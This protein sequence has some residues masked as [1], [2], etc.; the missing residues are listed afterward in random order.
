MAKAEF[1][2]YFDNAPASAEQLALFTEIRIDQGIGIAA[3]A[4]LDLP[5]GTDDAGLWPGI[6]EDFAQ[7]FARVRIEVKVAE[8]DFL[9]L[10][11]GL[12]VGN[13]YEMSAAPNQSLMTL[14]VQDDSVQ[15]SRDEK[16]A[17][18]E[19]MAPADIVTSLFTDAGLTAEVDAAPDA[20]AALQRVIVQRGTSMQLLRELA[21]RHGMFVYVRPGEAPG[22]S[23]G[24]FKRPRLDAS[25]LPEIMLVG[26]KRN[27]AS[28][29]AEFDAL[30]PIKAQA[31][32]VS[33]ADKSVLSSQ[34]EAA[35]IAPLGDSAA[36]DVTQAA[37]VLL[38]G[39]RE[40]Q[41]DLDAATAATVELS[42]WAY[43]A[44]GELDA[45]HY[46]GVMQPHHLVRVRGIGGYLSGDYLIG[47]VRHVLTDSGYRQHFSLHRNARSAGGAGA[48]GGLP[49]GVF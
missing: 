43:A 23:V 6:E 10:I 5:V 42:S 40:E 34:T 35:D 13:R 20:G 38:T 2:V 7:P 26:D 41:T 46:D 39:T 1:R 25:D 4:E 19:D 12:I 11:D 36:H 17:L 47:R 27:V 21:R 15:L 29:S 22:V 3:E 8:A 32:S 28:F 14:V 49:S 24:V 33:L 31:G 44:K 37:V 9:P 30:R 18:F 45:E 48:G 16:V